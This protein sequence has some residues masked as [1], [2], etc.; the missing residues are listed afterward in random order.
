MTALPAWQSAAL[1]TRALLVLTAMVVLV[2][3]L[4]LEVAP[5]H[6]GTQLQPVQGPLK[7]LV[8]R[9]INLPAA[10]AVP[11]A[12]APAPRPPRARGL[13]E[14][15]T[16]AL[17]PPQPVATESIATPAPTLAIPLPP[18]LSEAA[19][20]AVAAGAALSIPGSVRFV[21][22]M[23]GRSKGMDYNAAAE[24]S[25]FQDGQNYEAKMSVSALF[26]GVRSMSSSGRITA[27]G[28]APLRFS[29][30]SRGE[31]ATHFDA[32]KGKITFSANTPD[33]PWLSGAQDRVSVFLQLASMLA[34][35]PGKYPNGSTVSLYTAG[36]REV[37]TW[38]FIV[39]GPEKLSLP[40]GE[41]QALKLRRKP[42]R[43]YDQAIEVWL[44]PSLDWLPVRNRITQH[45]GDFV[46]QQ[47]SSREKPS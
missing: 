12:P 45:N 8:T 1:P 27:D 25:W 47:L 38:T 18:V 26:L 41:V 37:D 11:S 10:A 16:P 42:Q 33:A 35:D 13:Q 30:K 15:A 9:T 28:L 40:I 29:D 19:T 46:D 2:H 39:E 3:V 4:L 44:A 7:P 31:R 20:P 6:W 43:D 21:Y 14:N 36:P 24:L 22:A 5:A 34:G 32:D 17:A 23:T